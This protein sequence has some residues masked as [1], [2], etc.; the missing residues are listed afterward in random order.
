MRAI[1]A[2]LVSTCLASA[3]DGP[4]YPVY[5]QEG[6]IVSRHGVGHDTW[7]EKFYSTLVREDGSSCCNF[8][9]CRPTVSR[10]VGNHYEVMIDRK[11]VA[12]PFSTIKKVIAPDH[13]AHVCAPAMDDY[14]TTPIYCVVL[15]PEG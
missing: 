6:P 14:N 15:P 13:G 8:N 1:L 11:W 12:V 5:A 9:D 7:H 10:M 3:Q 2:L 4:N